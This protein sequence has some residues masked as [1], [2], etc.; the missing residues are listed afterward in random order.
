MVK[1]QIGRATFY[2]ALNLINIDQQDITLDFNDVI[3]LCY[4]LNNTNSFTSI[5]R[6]KDACFPHDAHAEDI[7]HHSINNL[8][9]LINNVKNSTTLLFSIWGVIYFKAAKTD[10][11]DALLLKRFL[12]LSS[13]AFFIASILLLIKSPERE[14]LDN[15]V[16]TYYMENKGNKI[17]II[18]NT[19]NVLPAY[20]IEKL[21]LLNEHI[22]VFYFENDKN[23]TFSAFRDNNINNK[24]HIIDKGDQ[25]NLY[26]ELD[27]ALR[28]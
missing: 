4:L 28:I 16:S 9:A 3:I 10:N 14:Y 12:A 1:Y 25:K 20:L 5:S 11:G 15:H 13:L 8:K 26:R 2:P 24:S 17:T 18:N 6:V 19:N 22:K 21:T 23:I 27:R 7:I